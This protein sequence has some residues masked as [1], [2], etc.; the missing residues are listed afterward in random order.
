M[1]PRSLV[2]LIFFHLKSVIKSCHHSSLERGSRA[3]NP[4]AV[5]DPTGDA[6]PVS[7]TLHGGDIAPEPTGSSRVSSG[8]KM[9]KVFAGW[10][11]VLAPPPL[12]SLRLDRP[13]RRSVTF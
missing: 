3:M 4:P 5:G 10:R 9:P 12:P 13:A 11:F 8:K 6:G 2:V 7:F 1:M